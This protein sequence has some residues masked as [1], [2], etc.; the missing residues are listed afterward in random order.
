MLWPDISESGA[1][2]HFG[3]CFNRALQGRVILYG[4]SLLVPGFCAGPTRGP[5]FLLCVRFPFC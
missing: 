1:G 3:I 4:A 5:P 2:G